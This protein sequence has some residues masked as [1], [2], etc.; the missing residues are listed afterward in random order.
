MKNDTLMTQALLPKLVVWTLI[1][2]FVGSAVGSSSA[3]FLWLLDVVTEAR[4][5]YGVLIFFLPL[6]G[7]IIGIVYHFFANG[8]EKE[9]NLLI[10]EMVEPHRRI[11]WKLAPLVVVG[12]L[13]THLFGGSAGREGTA[14]QMGGAIADW[15]GG[16]FKTIQLNRKIILR[17]GAAAGFAGVFGTP[18]AGAVFAVELD[19]A[20]AFN[21]IGLLPIVLVSFLSDLSCQVWGVS[22][23]GYTISEVPIFTLQH[24][25][26]VLFLGGIFGGVAGLFSWGKKYLTEGVQQLLPNSI[27]RLSLG[28]LLLAVVF[29]TLNLEAYSGLGIPIIQDA[30]TEASH[31]GVFAVKF[32]FTLFTLAVGFKGGEATPL[33][34]IGATLGSTL[35]IYFGLPLSFVAGLGFI[36]VFA[37]ATN[38]PLACAIMGVEMFGPTGGLWYLLVCVVAFYTSGRTTVY[39]A[40][41]VHVL[42]YDF[43]K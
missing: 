29:V 20:R 1:I 37:G 33:F 6:G 34:F 12:T 5:N 9:T 4:T 24:I 32:L 18:L 43:R 22:H 26:S 8:V 35:A 41:R 17:M 23:T 25:G 42:K 40:Q 39:S 2:L 14:V 21:L 11:H 3:L 28:G 36:A 10:D 31:G 19:R 16:L 30:F 15:I 38:T 7:L 13:L 27:V